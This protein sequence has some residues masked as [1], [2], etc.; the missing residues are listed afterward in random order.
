M[1]VLNLVFDTP[2]ILFYHN[3]FPFVKENIIR[4]MIFSLFNKKR[5]ETLHILP[6]EMVGN[7]CYTI[8]EPREKK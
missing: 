2:I 1:G 8:S 5:M 6:I 7:M 4:E 3:K